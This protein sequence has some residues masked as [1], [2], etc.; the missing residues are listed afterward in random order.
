MKY[1]DDLVAGIKDGM[2]RREIFDHCR[3]QGE[4]YLQGRAVDEAGRS[5]WD[6]L[7]EVRDIEEKTDLLTL[8]GGGYVFYSIFHPIQ[9]YLDNNLWVDTIVNEVRP[10]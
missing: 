5:V 1:L 4:E 10:V 9:F 8:R 6:M 7:R 3:K 2:R